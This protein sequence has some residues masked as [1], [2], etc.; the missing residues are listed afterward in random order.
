MQRAA[1]RAGRDPRLA[2]LVDRPAVVE[3]ALERAQ[4]LV[5]GGE[6]ADLRLDEVR[7]VAAEAAHVEHQPADVAERQLAGAA[8][9]AQPPA[10]LAAVAE[11]RAAGRAA[12]LLL[13]DDL[14]VGVGSGCGAPA[15]T[16]ATGPAGRG[17]AGWPAFLPHGMRLDPRRSAER[18]SA[19]QAGAAAAW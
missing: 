19:E 16:G 12:G 13:D 5:D 18:K 15:A 6:R 14:R 3:H 4:L 2:Q 7:A 17:G 1:A 11:A 8:Q 9:E 10:Q